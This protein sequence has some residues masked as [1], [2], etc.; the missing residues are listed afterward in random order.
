MTL[1]LAMSGPACGMVAPSFDTFL[2]HSLGEWRG[3][4]YTWQ[5]S[6]TDD[7]SSLLPLGIAPGFVTAPTASSTTV[8]EVM[9]SC[10]GAVQGVEEQRRCQP[11][12]GNVVLNRQTDGTSFFSYGSYAVAPTLLSSPS[13]DNQDFLASTE[14]FGLSVCIAHAD[15]TRRRIL[16][17]VA[18]DEVPCADVAV[19]ASAAATEHPEAPA[20]E[21][22]GAL[23]DRR[24]QCIVE[25]S[26]WEGGADS[27]TLT[28]TPQP[29]NGPWLN[30]RTRWTKSEAAIEGGASLVPP[31][32]VYLPGGCWI[33]VDK[34]DNGAKTIEVG[35]VSAE[36]A[37]VKAIGHV[38]SGDGA[39]RSVY[40]R[41][42][43]ARE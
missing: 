19:E 36:A 4:S 23:L 39:L 35:S 33:T 42:T 17:V 2:K 14:A 9:R 7:Q 29:P 40:F 28:G 16:L 8:A 13:D 20:N 3:A 10:G 18:G 26:A 30:A 21:V 27:L 37:E 43:C 5:Q 12:D 24:L 41:K 22:V 34:D 38:F 1:L 31:G 6:A 32:G 11:A 25:A 15:A